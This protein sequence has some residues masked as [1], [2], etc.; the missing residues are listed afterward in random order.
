MCVQTGGPLIGGL[1]D[2][3]KQ[4]CSSSLFTLLLK[5]TD[6][7]YKC[8]LHCLYCLLW[9]MP[10]KHSVHKFWYANWRWS[11]VSKP[12]VLAWLL[13]ARKHA[14]II[15][16][17]RLPSFHPKKKT[18]KQI[19]YI[20]IKH[21]RIKYMCTFPFLIDFYEW[22]RNLMSDGWSH[23]RRLQDSRIFRFVLK[24]SKCIF[25]VYIALKY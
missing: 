20:I 9:L 7:H 3:F 19:M 4:Q 24:V 10:P 16:R 14:A 21:N 8:C 5:M 18:S 1:F 15:I 6:C 22:I 11:S 23:G 17:I 2:T 25:I 13:L 12:C